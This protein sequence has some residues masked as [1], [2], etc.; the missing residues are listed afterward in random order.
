MRLNLWLKKKKC[1][2]LENKRKIYQTLNPLSSNIFL[3]FFITRSSIYL[4]V[5]FKIVSNLS[6]IRYRYTLLDLD[7][8][9]ILVHYHRLHAQERRRILKESPA[10]IPDL[11]FV[12][13]TIDRHI[14]E[15]PL[16]KVLCVV[17]G[18]VV[19]RVE[20]HEFLLEFVRRNVRR[21]SLCDGSWR[22]SNDM[23][24]AQEQKRYC[25]R[26]DPPQFHDQDDFEICLSTMNQVFW[27][28]TVNVTTKSFQLQSD[29]WIAA[30][31]YLAKF[32]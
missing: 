19:L 18:V 30:Q 6:F 3:I 7:N 10:A 1:K 8:A 16:P 14:D 28:H 29:L 21:S 24:R 27:F 20:R 17:V 26:H 9:R 2:Y 4:F 23:D 12:R 22:Q 31:R 25:H 11:H 32:Y 15:G 5:S 13:W